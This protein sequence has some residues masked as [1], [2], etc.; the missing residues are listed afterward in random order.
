MGFSNKPIFPLDTLI[1][2]HQVSWLRNDYNIVPLLLKLQNG[3]FWP[4]QHVHAVSLLF[5]PSKCSYFQ[6]ART[7][8]SVYSVSQPHCRNSSVFIGLPTG[9]KKQTTFAKT[10]QRESG[11]ITKVQNCLVDL[12]SLKDALNGLN[13]NSRQTE[14]AVERLRRTACPWEW[15][16]RIRC[17]CRALIRPIKSAPFILGG[18]WTSLYRCLF[19]QYSPDWPYK[20][21]DWHQRQTA[22]TVRDEQWILSGKRRVRRQN[23]EK[24]R[25]EERKRVILTGGMLM[26]LMMWCHCRLQAST[27]SWKWQQGEEKKILPLGLTVCQSLP[28]AAH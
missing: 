4:E 7:I 3:S 21:N 12:K 24:E 18:L 10:K 11:A 27:E 17:A 8:L 16:G 19:R 14:L 9:H 25:K 20:P 6:P 23:E 13:S 26:M 2:A 15:R 22:G 1:Q 5:Y 28:L